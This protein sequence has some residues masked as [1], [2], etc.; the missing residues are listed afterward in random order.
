MWSGNAGASSGS[1][2]QAV[3]KIA[4]ASSLPAGAAEPILQGQTQA[5]SNT[6]GF[7][8]I[9]DNMRLTA[10]PGDYYLTVSLDAA[11]VSTSSESSSAQQAQQ[12]GSAF[13]ICAINALPFKPVR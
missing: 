6:T 9:V 3:V 7:M 2:L 12:R 5:R 10:V 13:Y 1:T 11:E 8:D 4:P